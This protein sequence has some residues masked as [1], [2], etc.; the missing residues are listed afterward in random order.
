MRLLTGIPQIAL[1]VFAHPDDADIAAGAT[2]ARWAQAGAEVTLVIATRG[3]KGTT[4]PS[5]TPE[6]L[7]S[8]RAKEVEA[9]VSFLGVH[10]VLRLGIGD[11]EI[12]NDDR[13]RAKLV[14]LIRTLKPQIVLTHDPAPVY[15]GQTYFNHR[16]HRELGFAV[17]DAVFP[18]AHLPHYFPE[19]GPP[20]RV[21]MVLMSGTADAQ[22]GIDVT[23]TLPL[24]K[25]AVACHASQVRGR[26]TE[27]QR[28]IDANARAFG[29]R[30]GVGAAEVFRELRNE[31]GER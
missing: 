4:D 23:A 2:I 20:H 13:L 28:S 14:E 11:G 21:E 7:A 12:V 8:A 6:E 3:E 15:F 27:V 30:L 17:L 5:V 25:E 16:D 9:A 1:C 10:R 29:K 19:A 24:K 18:A 22:V 31:M 26:V